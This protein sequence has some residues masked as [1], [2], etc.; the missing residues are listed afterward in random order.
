M[1]STGILL[2]CGFTAPSS[3]C[4]FGGATIILQFQ[5]KKV[6][7]RFQ[8]AEEKVGGNIEEVVVVDDQQEGDGAGLGLAH[9]P[10]AARFCST[11]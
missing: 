2:H 7:K 9:A 3:S 8:E 1:R 11:T 6:Q 10:A 5:I 4:R